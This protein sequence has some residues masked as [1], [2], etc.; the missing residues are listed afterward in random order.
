MGQ[1]PVIIMETPHYELLIRAREGS[2]FRPD[3]EMLE[4]RLGRIPGVASSGP[5]SWS[6]GEPDEHG[7]MSIEALE[8]GHV[9]IRFPR[10]WVNDRGPQVFALV[11]M[12]AEWCDGEV[13]DPQIDDV[14][15]KDIV[16]QGMVAVRQARR[17]QEQEQET[18]PE[19]PAPKSD[20]SP[21]SKRPWW[22]R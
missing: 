5:G 6:F 3:P 11:F 17:E 13:Y 7:S 20:A 22:K 19:G 2:G 10:P 1:P 9:R 8:T 21:K 14:L 18:A 4:T 16:L 15:R 12:T